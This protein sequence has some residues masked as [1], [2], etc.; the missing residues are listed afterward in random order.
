MKE[1]PIFLVGFPRSGTTLLDRFLGRHQQLHCL[2][3]KGL[4]DP[5][6]E[7]N[8][9]DDALREAYWKAVDQYWQPTEGMRLVDR[10]PI[11]F[12][13]ADLIQ[14]LWPG[15]PMVFLMRH[16]AD[17]VLS[18]FMQDFRPNAL[19]V[20]F[21]SIESTV[22]FYCESMAVWMRARDQYRD[23]IHEVRYEALVESPEPLLRDLLEWLGLAWTDAVLDHRADN[24]AAGTASY[25]Q[26]A[27]PIY[28]RAV[29]RWQRY[30]DELEP[31]LP[32]L[33]PYVSAF[34]YGNS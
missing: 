21:D 34:G 14:R 31:W 17:V 23:A 27:E 20:H 3:E 6:A 18:C 16:P 26:V 5:L 30:R 11:A 2:E 29:G 12:L 7:R 33:Q 8:D 24:T 25:H 22:S 10:M 15:A 1:P 4:L 19:T 13:H 9:P 32:Q 28:S